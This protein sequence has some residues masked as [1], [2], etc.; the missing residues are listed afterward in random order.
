MEEIN[1]IALKIREYRKVQ[2]MSQEELAEKSGINISTIKK[3]E[4]GNRNP[5][6]D[7]LLKIS[8]ALGVSINEFLDFEISTISD[9]MSI[10]MKLDEQTDMQIRG[11]KNKKGEYIPESITLSFSDTKINQALSSY[12]YSK[13][14][15]DQIQS[16]ADK[17][18]NSEIRTKSYILLDDIKIKLLI[19][20]DEISQ[21]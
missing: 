15:M 21:K 19:S 11:K 1:S 18:S 10:L 12:L 8:N 7:Q 4:V 9:V 2:N 14:E 20:S 3:Y 5:K 6:P 13:D 17:D 16:G